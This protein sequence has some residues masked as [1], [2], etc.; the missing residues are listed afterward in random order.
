MKAYLVTLAVGL[1][2]GAILG[3]LNARSPALAETVH[4][5][6]AERPAM[7]S[8]RFDEDWRVLCD[9]AN[10][11]QFLDPLKCIPMGADGFAKLTLGGELRE[12]FEIVANPGFG[13]DQSSDH[14]FL[15]RALLHGDLHL[16]DNARAFVQVGAFQQNG[17]EGD[18]SPTDV[19]RLDLTQAFI[20]LGVATPGDGRLTLR[21]GRQEMSFGASRLVSVRESPNVRRSFDG[22]RVFWTGGGYRVDVFNARP[23][24]LDQGDF[25]DRVNNGETLWGVY[26]TGPVPG[27]SGLKADLYHLGFERENARFQNSTADEKRQSSGLRLFG[28]RGGFDWDVEAVYQ[29]GDFGQR[30]IRAWTVASDVGFT[31]D[32]IGMLPRLG[33]KADI[34]SG[35]PDP[36][37]GRLGTFNALYPKFPYFSEANLIAPANVIDLQPSVR[38]QPTPGLE[39][40][41]AWNALWRQTTDD[42]IY[43]P[44]LAAIAGTAGRGS[45]F[46]GHQAI[47]GLEWRAT[48]NISVASQYVHFTPG[49]TLEDVGGDDVDFLFASVAFKF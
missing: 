13:L 26:G 11:T 5:A 25:D 8:H 18:R 31:L 47:L 32:W 2:A 45:R 10:R 39:V 43:E 44:P 17:R 7:K 23:I 19:D 48:P 12:R 36:G 41:L 4:D 9:P 21:G 35:D 20:D 1:L 3:P 15:H 34:A 22:G 24:T 6:G 27:I 29:F 14:V 49:G 16:G 30:D 28:E 33:L 42:A 40:E 38:F 37:D 46:I